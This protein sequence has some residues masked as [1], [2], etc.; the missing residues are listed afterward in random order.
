M[1]GLRIESVGDDTTLTHWQH[2]HNVIIPVDP[3]TIDE[4][5]E[6]VLRHRLEVAYRDDVLVANTTVR[7]PADGNSTATV[8]VRVLPDFR[9]QGIGT[10]FYERALDQLVRSGR[11]RSR[12]SSGPPRWMAAKFALEGICCEG[13]DLPDDDIPY[14][15][16]RL[17]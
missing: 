10:E 9:R 2:V 6:R 1:S 8:I 13:R 17:N 14:I 16:L 12:R 15:T 3:L 7:P 4:I 5:R 11:R